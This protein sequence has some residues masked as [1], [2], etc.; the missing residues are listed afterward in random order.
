VRYNY[1]VTQFY[2]LQ[3]LWE[4]QLKDHKDYWNITAAH[5]FWCE[6]GN[7]TFCGRKF[8][9]CENW[10]ISAMDEVGAE[11]L[12]LEDASKRINCNRETPVDMFH[13]ETVALTENFIPTK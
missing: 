1:L 3:H 8:A 10:L 2:Q 5:E 9:W 7:K 11:V 6:H 12:D 4:V 13:L